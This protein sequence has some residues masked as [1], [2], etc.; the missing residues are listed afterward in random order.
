MKIVIV[1]IVLVIA[2]AIIGIMYV[3]STPGSPPPV[4]TTDSVPAT[5]DTNS[6]VGPSPTS[7]S[8]TDSVPA[9]IDTNSQ[10]DTSNPTASTAVSAPTKK[11]AQKSNAIKGKCPRSGS[12]PGAGKKVCF[13]PCP[14]GTTLDGLYCVPN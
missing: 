4:T 7:A 14:T 5:I 11:L 13:G 6:Q 2:I 1:L 10:V 8:T 12:V 3:L 9:T